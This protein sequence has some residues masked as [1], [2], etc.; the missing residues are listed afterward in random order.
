VLCRVFLEGLVGGRWNNSGNAG[1][2]NWSHD[3]SLTNSNI[4][5]GFRLS[6]ENIVTPCRLAK[7]DKGEVV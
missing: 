1:L 6:I 7:N 2:Y 5:Y 3:N 4:N